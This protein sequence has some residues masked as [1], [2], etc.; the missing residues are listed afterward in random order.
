GSA[1]REHRSRGACDCR[2]ATWP[3]QGGLRVGADGGAVLR[4]LDWRE[5]C[6][7]VQ[8]ARRAGGCG[9]G[10]Q[11]QGERQAVGGAVAEHAH[12]EGVGVSVRGCRWAR[13]GGEAW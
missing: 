12:G 1:M 13:S 2:V 4:A 3:P 8:E 5:V 6:T 9:E 10:E 7:G 11:E